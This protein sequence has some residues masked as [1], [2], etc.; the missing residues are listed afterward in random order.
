MYLPTSTVSYPAFCSQT[1]TVAASWT[2]WKCDVLSWSLFVNPVLCGYLSAMTSSTV[3]L[4]TLLR[5][6]TIE[7]R[8]LRARDGCGRT[9]YP[10]VLKQIYDRPLC[11]GGLFYSTVQSRWLTVM[12]SRAGMLGNIWCRARLCLARV[13]SAAPCVRR[14]L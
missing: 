14:L 2:G 12:A 7:A 3:C 1:L 10:S 5:Q 8:P 4:Q 9:V 11:S 6:H 13:C